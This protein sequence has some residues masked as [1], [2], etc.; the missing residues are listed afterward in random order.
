MK[1][2]S[3]T[4]LAFGF[5]LQLSVL[6]GSFLPV[7]H[8]FAQT[9]QTCKTYQAN[10]EGITGTAGH[11]TC[12]A[13][14][15]AWVTQY[16]IQKP[17]NTTVSLTGSGASTA[18]YVISRPD[19]SNFATIPSNT[20][21]SIVV[22]GVCPP[23]C[24]EKAGTPH[25]MAAGD[26]NFVTTDAKIYGSGVSPTAYWCSGGCYVEAQRGACFGAGSDRFCNVSGSKL[27]GQNCTDG[28]ADPSTPPVTGTTPTAATAD[29]KSGLCEGTFN[30][31]VVKHKC[32]QS[33]QTST[34]TTSTATVTSTGVTTTICK[35]GRCTT[36]TTITD[37]TG[38]TTVVPP[39][40]LSK[41]Y[42]DRP[43]FRIR[44]DGS[45][46]NCSTGC[47]NAFAPTP[48]NPT[49]FF[50]TAQCNACFSDPPAP[51]S[52]PSSTT[53]NSSTTG[54][55][56]DKFCEKNPKSAQCKGDTDS[57]F[58]GSCSAG[59]TCSGDAA[60]CAAA[61]GVHETKCNVESLKTEPTN[62][63][64]QAGNAALTAGDP[65]DHPKNN[66]ATKDIGTFDQTN[67]FGNS[68]PA[69]QS[70]TIYK[71][72]SMVI[73]WSSACGSLIIMGNL[74]VGF[75]MLISAFWLVKG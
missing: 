2:I 26:S 64:V 69:D 75:T 73:P 4:S 29:D 8:L 55:G 63:T 17:G 23:T 66:K 51:V 43:P 37:K 32:A 6:L 9:A 49:G 58:G 1:A 74:L 16:N 54:E 10:F 5:C 46:S 42:A 59:F 38:P 30:G 40:D 11:R 48:Q 3:W 45:L 14:A 13:A 52:I 31:T 15:S 70:F 65:S 19:G 57:S 39:D 41:P 27:T 47:I 33:D 67:P 21:Q 25:F 7:D 62:A 22:A 53:S 44:P 12:G 50:S 71:G 36:T 18:S 68:C 34:T 60:Q 56:S 72:A 35:D 61:K 28:A 24:A 20:C